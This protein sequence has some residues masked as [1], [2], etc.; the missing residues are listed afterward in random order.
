PQAAALLF[1]S[2]RFH[3]NT[4]LPPHPRPLCLEDRPLLRP[5][6][7][8]SAKL[9]PQ[10]P[11]GP[12]ATLSDQRPRRPISQSLQEHHHARLP[13][14]RCQSSSGFCCLGNSW[15]DLEQ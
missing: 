1:P 6:P 10:H 7:R 9:V 15:I 8:G 4:L 11:L 2:L 13:Y 12:A 14:A 3:P 5:P